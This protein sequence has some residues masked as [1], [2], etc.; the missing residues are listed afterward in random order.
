MVK[1]IA[2]NAYGTVLV[3]GEPLPERLT[4]AE[5]TLLEAVLRR[6]SV[7]TK[8][9]LLQEL[10][11][12]RDEPEMKIIDVFACKLRRKLGEHREAVSTVW[13][14]GYIRGEGYVH[15]VQS[16]QVGVSTTTMAAIDDLAELTGRKPTELTERLLI[17]AV[18]S[19]RKRFL[20]AQEFRS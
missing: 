8:E 14:R 10:Y 20:E 17:D 5:A 6:S 16:A 9:M 13:A 15:G 1:A 12:G 11:G 18:A 4:R 2:V 7:C 19:A 3:D